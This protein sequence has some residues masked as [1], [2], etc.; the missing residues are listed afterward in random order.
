MDGMNILVLD[1]Q[2][3]RHDIFAMLF[4]TAIHA[5]TIDDCINALEWENIEVLFLDY[6]LKGNQR[7]DPK[8]ETGW[9]VANWIKENPAKSPKKIII[10]SLNPGGAQRIMDLDI[11][12]EWK[13][14]FWKDIVSEEQNVS[15]ETKEQ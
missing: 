1:D 5:Y 14:A 15:H 4:K 7:N 10:H 6:D 2:Q 11:G 13:P 12:A 9:A 3:R 8:E